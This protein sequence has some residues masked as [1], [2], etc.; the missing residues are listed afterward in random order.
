MLWSGR[1]CAVLE[2]SAVAS[3]LNRLGPSMSFHLHCHPLTLHPR[4]SWGNQTNRRVGYPPDFN[5]AGRTEKNATA[6]IDR[7]SDPFH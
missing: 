5:V 2:K 6:K 7:S 4:A 1:G 3:T